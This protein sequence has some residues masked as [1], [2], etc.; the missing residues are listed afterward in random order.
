MG[1]IDEV[2]KYGRALAVGGTVLGIAVGDIAKAGVG[3][4]IDY[5]R[6]M[7]DPPPPPQIVLRMPDHTTRDQGTAEARVFEL[8]GA[9]PRQIRDARWGALS[10]VAFPELPVGFYLIQVEAATQQGRARREEAVKYGGDT[11]VITLPPR[12]D[13]SWQSLADAATATRAAP[14]P[15][16]SPEL[17]DA[18]SL[19]ALVKAPPDDPAWRWLGAALV[20]LGVSERTE[21]DRTRI[22]SYFAAT[23]LPSRMWSADLGWSSAFLNT[24]FARAGIQAT[25]A[26]TNASWLAWGSG[27]E[28]PRPGAVAV[29]RVRGAA[30][31]GLPQHF[32]GLLLELREDCALLLGG[33]LNNSVT[34][35][36]FRPDDVE[37]YRWPS[38]PMP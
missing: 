30:S 29:V 3:A 32:A 23:S 4:S 14:P 21:A 18:A 37:A 5:V 33:N 8:D 15:A 16:P 31:A 2:K 17:P 1:M 36:C 11:T 35:R 10:V 25:R 7:I 20:E 13:A 34:A 38:E 26:G 6:R 27:L 12:T 9:V 22:A 24:V 19:R 28:T